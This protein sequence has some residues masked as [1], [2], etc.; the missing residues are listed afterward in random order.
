MI[1][2]ATTE[3]LGGTNVLCLSA[4]HANGSRAKP[5][6]GFSGMLSA[7][8]SAEWQPNDQPHLLQRKPK[9]V[10]MQKRI[11]VALI[12][13]A[14][15][16]SSYAGWNGAG[17]LPSAVSQEKLSL[18]RTAPDEGNKDFMQAKLSAINA[19]MKAASTDNFAAVEQAGLDL[20]QLSKQAA[21]NRHADAAYLQDTA[22]F[23]QS[24]EFMMRM[25]HA[26]D[27]QGVASSFGAVATACFNC[28][29]HVRT[30]K[31]A[32]NFDAKIGVVAS[33]EIL[34]PVFR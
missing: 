26:K 32:V 9:V 13:L 17:M 21:W 19:A 10:Q 20:V 15:A 29:R 16:I 8:Q 33:A 31:V 11:R 28:H 23:V 22:D 6:S 14:L 3:R 5:L 4:H 1:L 2:V 18:K 30:P 12:A 27:S 7:I 24:A 34:S 25:A